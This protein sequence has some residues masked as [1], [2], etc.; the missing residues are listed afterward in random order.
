MVSGL[1]SWA[2][3]KLTAS[4]SLSSSTAPASAAGTA[5]AAQSVLGAT[6]RG[7]A[8]RVE[9]RG[10]GWDDDD[11]FDTSEGDIHSS[12]AQSRSRLTSLADQ[13]TQGVGEGPGDGWGLEEDA[14]L[15]AAAD[16]GMSTKNASMSRGSASTT[17][18]GSSYGVKAP[19]SSG[20]QLGMATAV[21]QSNLAADD[22]FSMLDDSSR[23]KGFHQVSEPQSRGPVASAASGTQARE[24]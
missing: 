9:G 1:A 20:L 7:G 16:D 6:K 5:T 8:A 18:L 13:S 24:R 3:N 11:F 21:R 19:P 15:L 12:A 17:G 2:A 4:P 22:F 10:D 14:D 23:T